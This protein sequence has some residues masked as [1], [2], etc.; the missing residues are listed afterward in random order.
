MN[1]LLRTKKGF[2]LVIDGKVD[3]SKLEFL[4]KQLHAVTGDEWAVLPDTQFTE[5]YISKEE[6]RTMMR[7]TMKKKSEEK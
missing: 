6:L 7:P 4:A 2:L 5:E 1:K 3:I